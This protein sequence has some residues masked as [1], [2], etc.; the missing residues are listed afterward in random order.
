MERIHR[1]ACSYTNARTQIVEK[2]ISLAVLANNR[3]RLSRLYA[4]PYPF[5]LF[6]YRVPAI[7][8]GKFCSGTTAWRGTP[9]SFCRRLLTLIPCT[10]WHWHGIRYITR[11]LADAWNARHPRADP[12]REERPI[13]Y[14][15]FNESPVERVEII[16]RY[17]FAFYDIKILRKLDHLLGYPIIGLLLYEFIQW[18]IG[19]YHKSL[20]DREKYLFPIRRYL[21]SLILHEKLKNASWRRFYDRR[22]ATAFY[23]F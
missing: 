19:K 21:F 3:E 7:V 11:R 4:A 9:T 16:R 13:S 8:L 6:P 17:S 22:H 20:R 1:R 10:S 18:C 5:T 15:G 23:A 14:F 2:D 12:S